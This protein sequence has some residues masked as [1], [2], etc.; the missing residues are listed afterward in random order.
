[1]ACNHRCTAY[2]Q[3]VAGAAG[4]FVVVHQLVAVQRANGAMVGIIDL[5]A[6]WLPIVDTG[7]QLGE[8]GPLSDECRDV[9]FGHERDDQ[10]A[11]DDLSSAVDV[12]TELELW[13]NLVAR[14]STVIVLPHSTVAFGRAVR[15]IRLT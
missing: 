3:R 15:V 10:L 12:E 5:L 4:G 7:S 8:P 13:T 2:D 14:E 9:F 1:M 11:L 6:I